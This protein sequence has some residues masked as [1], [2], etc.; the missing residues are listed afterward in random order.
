MTSLAYKGIHNP[1][2]TFHKDNICMDSTTSTT[3]EPEFSQPPSSPPPTFP[4][5]LSGASATKPSGKCYHKRTKNGTGLQ[6][7]AFYEDN[8]LFHSSK[9][10]VVSPELIETSDLSCSGTWTLQDTMLQ[11]KLDG[12]N[13]YVVKIAPDGEIKDELTKFSP[14]T[15]VLTASTFTETASFLPWDENEGAD[16]EYD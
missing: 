9:I 8:T 11:I 16:S 5:L 4:L 1:Q 3:A 7:Y 10:E 13:G 15:F 6:K 14:S 12:L 2:Q